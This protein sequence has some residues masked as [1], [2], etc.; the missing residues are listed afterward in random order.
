MS[1]EI[2]LWK[3]KIHTNPPAVPY[4][5]SAWK[6]VRM[7]PTTGFVVT[8]P[9]RRII[10][11]YL[12]HFVQ[13]LQPPHPNPYFWVS[14]LQ[15]L[16][17]PLSRPHNSQ[18]CQWWWRPH[19]PPAWCCSPARSQLPHTHSYQLSTPIICAKVMTSLHPVYLDLTS[20]ACA[21]NISP[22]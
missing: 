10:D 22:V 9:L 20:D 2:R 3:F 6:C 5:W 12:W 11:E 4:A 8:W 14:P 18:E 15:M 13:L 16:R 17:A 1:V 19:L 7:I 21:N